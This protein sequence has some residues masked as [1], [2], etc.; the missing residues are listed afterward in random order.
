MPEIERKA[1]VLLNLMVVT[2]LIESFEK[3]IWS[4]CHRFDKLCSASYCLLR[5]DGKN[6]EKIFEPL[7][8]TRRLDCTSK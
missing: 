5:L 7:N 2:F 1:N 8:P 3:V 6:V 4:S